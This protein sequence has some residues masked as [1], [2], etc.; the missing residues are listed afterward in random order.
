MHEI[1]L[2]RLDL[3]L[4]MALHALL[5]ERS[6][7]RAAQTLGLSQSATSHALNRLRKLFDDPLLVRTSQGMIPTPRAENLLEPLR[8]IL[9]E[10]E[11]LIQTPTFD[12]KTAQGTIQI[13]ATDYATVVILPRV[14]KRVAEEAPHLDIECH[15]WREDTLEQLRNGAIDLALGGQNPPDS[16]E[17]NFQQLFVEDFVSIVRADHPVTQS[18]FTLEAFLAWSHALIT[19]TN[20][21]MGYID[22]VLKKLGVKRRILLRLPHFLS[23]PLIVA[24]TDL[25]LTLPR[26]LAMLFAEFANLC[27]LDPPV[28]LDKFNYIQV[29]H[30][31][32][33]HEPMHTWLRELIASQMLKV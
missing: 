25:I 32:R 6:V 30:K 29:W 19:V 20:S 17:F 2:A 3:N 15:H 24:K 23:A 22:A 13:V 10:I 28:E 31:R 5:K 8:Q 12:P 18:E 27:L 21:R 11:Q 33:Q 7:T 4:L 14:L 16:N 1:N 26:R 9:S